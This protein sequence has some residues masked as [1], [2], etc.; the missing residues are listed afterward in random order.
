[1]PQNP[2]ASS[3]EGPNLRSDAPPWRPDLP[4]WVFPG[5]MAPGPPIRRRG[6]RC[7]WGC[8]RDHPGRDQVRLQDS[9]H[10]RNRERPR[11]EVAAA[12]A[13]RERWPTTGRPIPARAVGAPAPEQ[14]SGSDAGPAACDE[15]R[16]W[17][18]TRCHPV[19]R[20]PAGVTKA[21]PAERSTWPQAVA[22]APSRESA[23][24]KTAQEAAPREKRAPS[25]A[26]PTVA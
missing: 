26:E 2:S 18:S 22:P 23:S 11:H 14:Q 5:R 7:A 1:M 16:P 13:G 3:T 12:R 15:G 21:P 4:H 24:M 20:R 8:P 10:R 17:E 9:D 25:E 6:A 19:V